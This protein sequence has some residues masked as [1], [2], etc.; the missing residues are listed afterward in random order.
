CLPATSFTWADASPGFGAK[1]I[2]AFTGDSEERFITKPADLNG[3]G[4]MDLLFTSTDY[5][6]SGVQ[7]KLFYAMSDGTQLQ[8]AGQAGNYNLPDKSPFAFHVL[9]YNGDGNQDVM[10]SSGGNWVVHLSTGNQISTTA[11]DTQV[12]S[13]NLDRSIV[14]D[15]NSDG[16]ADI[17]Y[18][19]GNAN[20]SVR[21][22]E[23]IESPP[24]SGTLINQFKSQ[25]DNYDFSSLLTQIPLQADEPGISWSQ[26]GYVDWKLKFEGFA[27]PRVG[28]FDGD[29]RV[30]VVAVVNS[31]Y[32]LP[33]GF[34]DPE[35]VDIY[36]TLV[37]IRIEQDGSFNISSQLQIPKYR[38]VQSKFSIPDDAFDFV[39]LDL[40]NDGLTDVITKVFSGAIDDGNYTTRV[41]LNTG[42][43][44][45]KTR[46]SQVQDLG[47]IPN[48][49]FMYFTDYNHDGYLDMVN[50]PAWNAN[51]DLRLWDSTN[52]KFS[53]PSATNL[54]FSGKA[55]NIPR[56]RIADSYIF[57]DI[58]ADGHDDAVHLE[59][60]GATNTPEKAIYPS[61]S[62]QRAVNV[63][64]GI[65]N[66]FGNQTTIRYE[67]LTSDTVYSRETDAL[68][69]QW[70]LPGGSH[71]LGKM[72]P[73]GN[74]YLAVFDLKTPA[75]VVQSAEST[76]PAAAATPGQ[77]DPGAVS[78]ISYYY[79]GAKAQAGGRGLLGFHQIK[80]IDEQTGVE[81]TTTYR[82][83]YPFT[84]FPVE[85]RVTTSPTDGST[86]LN[87]SINVWQLQGWDGISTAPPP[88]YQPFLQQST[89]KTYDLN[90]GELL[91]TVTT[92]NSYD[93]AGNVLD[94]ILQTQDN[95]R[96]ETYTQQTSSQYGSSAYDKRFGRLSRSQVTHSRTGK[97]SITRVSEFK[98]NT[99]GSLTGLL[100]QE[101]IEPGSPEKLVTT[102]EYDSRGNKSKITQVGAKGKNG[103]GGN[104]A[105]YQRFEY[106]YNNLL[107]RRYNSQE[108]L[109][110]NI[111]SRNELG[112][113]TQSQ[114]INGVVTDTAYDAFGREYFTRDSTGAYLDTRY[115]RSNIN[116]PGT[117]QYAKTTLAAGGAQTLTCFDALGR[118][119]LTA[120]PS[121]DG[122]WIAVN[123]EY[124]NLGRIKH[125]SNPHQLGT[126]P[127]NWTTLT[128]DVLG[129]VIR[130]D[131]PQNPDYPT[132]SFSSNSYDG[133][134]TTSINRKGQT[135]TETRNALDEIVTITDGLG[136]KI[137]NDYDAT[138]NLRVTTTSGP[139]QANG[140]PASITINMAYDNFGRKRSMNDP[141]QGNWSYDYNAFG[142][143]VEQRDNKG[144]SSLIVYD[145]LGRQAIRT[146]IKSGGS[147]EHQ[148]IWTYVSNPNGNGL[149][150]ISRVTEAVSG[151]KKT[152]TY[153]SLGRLDETTTSI[154][155]MSKRTE[156]VTYD[157]FGRIFQSF[158]AA[159]DYARGN[160]TGIEN[161]YNGFGYLARVLDADVQGGT[162]RE[163]YAVGAMDKWGN[164]TQEWLGDGSYVT[165]R[166]YHPV[167]G[168]LQAIYTDNSLFTEVQQNLVMEF[169]VL[170][171]LTRRTDVLRNRVEA[172]GYDGLNRLISTK[173]TE[174]LQ[175]NVTYDS[176]GNIRSKDGV[177]T[178]TYSQGNAGPHAVS[179]TSDGSNTTDYSYDA[180]GNLTSDSNGRSVGYSTYNKPLVISKGSN[181]TTFSYDPDRARY[182]RTDTDPTGTTTT[183]YIGSVEII[184][185]P[186]GSS[187]VKRYINGKTLISAIY[188]NAGNFQSN[189][190][191][192]LL[193][194][195]LG[196]VNV[197]VKSDTTQIPLS[198]DAW[199]QRRNA[200]TWEEMLEQ[201]R[202]DFDTSITRH[203][204]TSHEMIDKTGF[205]H[206]NGR[207]YDPRLGRFASADFLIQDPGLSQSYNRY[208]YVINN[209]LTLNDPT[210]QIFQFLLP[211]LA[212]YTT[213]TIAQGI[214]G[215]FV[216]PISGIIGCATGNI[217]TCAGATAGTNYAATGD[218]KA[219]LKAGAFS[220]A[221]ATAF[222][223]IGN[224]FENIAVNQG[225]PLSSI[226]TAQKIAEHAA[227]GGVMSVL[228]G[229][230]FGHGFV[231][232]GIV[233]S[234]A[235]PISNLRGEGLRGARV[236]AAA[237]V[238][239]TASEL[240]GGEFANG[241]TTGAFSYLFN[242]AAHE[243][244]KRQAILLS[245]A[246]QGQAR[247]I[248][249]L[250]LQQ[251]R[252]TFPD[253]ANEPNNFSGDLVIELA[254]DNML[255]SLSVMR[256][257]SLSVVI[258][259]GFATVI[260]ATVGSVVLAPF[261]R[262]SDL[263]TAITIGNESMTLLP[264]N[265]PSVRIGCNRNGCISA[266]DIA[267]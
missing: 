144:Q 218:F 159:G 200:L 176:Y 99:G 202:L 130:I 53:A 3:D 30:D 93:D 127:A 33:T 34:G 143:L 168:Y 226:Q 108:H 264:I 158:D 87:H 68:Q 169:D 261:K 213:T 148:T 199:G 171:N 259:E 11:I 203:G 266:I 246:A 4:K 188:D 134:T 132:L 179:R 37:F 265:D 64:T 89:E 6:N 187:E 125:K 139:T 196:S 178:Y 205:I 136:G 112:L 152:F 214:F 85:T 23:Q 175:K 262:I 80:S 238:G 237:I 245:R 102:H 234:F 7:H 201:A 12:P 182:Q 57:M 109:V 5:Q 249:S 1:K 35:T 231:S 227:V 103:S 230:K 75:Y 170:G 83:D 24:G 251:M 137:I 45:G 22:M 123:T 184:T 258:S 174:Q 15:F 151:F 166:N 180:N 131:H 77:V 215:D 250:S 47:V 91:S 189:K 19:K 114:D 97:P 147:T 194:D 92:T 135:K 260:D 78:R 232:T 153:D 84:G 44:D 243:L 225:K 28:D 104:Q 72:I 105:R 146:D 157:E 81:T 76:A 173:I 79:A 54:H 193:K 236:V 207:V 67:P 181:F 71:S 113:S 141:D 101:I 2:M 39:P 13:N 172:F 60:S 32:W 122:T 63:I 155:G 107:A 210:G 58:D 88:P 48:A 52:N 82:Q 86:L 191:D 18:D 46:F 212:A 192:L 40:N 229:G 233:Q 10:R 263:S 208:S 31:Y 206:M 204:Y 221:S 62:G 228:Q 20:Y 257:N 74:E 241:A 8:V 128:Y 66:G 56:L 255:R 29:G 183:Y 164:I 95:I 177:G 219:S 90:G 248:D 216:T 217:A 119:I 161:E 149:G 96:N 185:Y 133:F 244:T 100:S 126:T 9:D 167:T 162:Q 117:T 154:P 142:E 73:G 41:F 115:S 195:H 256:I 163:L 197:I 106:D 222:N 140:V 50:P 27:T 242:D 252:G 21:Y 94:I 42:T 49:T 186:D 220:W 150:Q 70:T 120:S 110:E 69:A 239:G 247:M 160:Y 165:N 118:E 14:V 145:D 121:F 190:T 16:L 98:Y 55:A 211:A 124:D 240:T 138:G 38:W 253:L 36:K 254:R 43:G 51:M 26:N 129:R 156:K 223:A 59:F 224:Q 209:P 267:P 116:C 65:D 25:E 61:N 198:F 235:A 111:L 17:L